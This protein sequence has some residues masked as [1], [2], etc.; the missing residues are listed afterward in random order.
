MQGPTGNTVELMFKGEVLHKVPAGCTSKTRDPLTSTWKVG[1][2]L[3]LLKNM[4][5]RGLG[6]NMIVHLARLSGSMKDPELSKEFTEL[7][8][9]PFTQRTIKRLD[10]SETT[11]LA[12]SKRL[13]VGFYFAYLGNHEVMTWIN[14][15][16]LSRTRSAYLF[17]PTRIMG[18]IS[19]RL[20]QL[21]GKGRF[22]VIYPRELGELWSPVADGALH[23]KSGQESGQ[24]VQGNRPGRVRLGTKHPN[25][26]FCRAHLLDES[27]PSAVNLINFLQ[28]EVNNRQFKTVNTYSS[29]V[30]STLGTC[31]VLGK[32]I[33]QDPLVCRF[34]RRIHRLKPPKTTL[35]P[36][37]ELVTVLNQGRG[38]CQETCRPL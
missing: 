2:I 18:L 11:P 31:P 15:E 17:L 26:N 12:T 37:W 38:M 6:D 3:N 28:F 14:L 27:A 7:Q 23:P 33:G 13:H 29:A 1:H 19:N 20:Y 16:V 9:G 36:S 30:S 25:R 22:I 5:A 34:M 8:S 4:T 24:L 10:Q 21:R 35:F 32:R